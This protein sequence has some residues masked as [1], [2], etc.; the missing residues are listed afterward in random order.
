MLFYE[1]SAGL[2]SYTYVALS[3]SYC[4]RGWGFPFRAGKVQYL[5]RYSEP[6]LLGMVPWP[7]DYLAQLEYYVSTQA[8]DFILLTRPHFRRPFLVL[9]H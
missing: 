6:A 4:L 5:T 7:G 1:K 2:L 3:L 9:Q 8:T